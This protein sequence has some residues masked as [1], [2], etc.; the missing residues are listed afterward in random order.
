MKCHY[1]DKTRDLR[2]YGPRAAMVCFGCAMSTPARK[3]E[4][5]RNF[6]TQLAASGPVACIDGTHVGPYPAEHASFEGSNTGG[7]RK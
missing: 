5:A 3:E 6:G 4:A 7:N 1:C 2:P